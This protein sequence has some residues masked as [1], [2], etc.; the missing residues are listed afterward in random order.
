MPINFNNIT[1][2]A[3]P[4]LVGGT[5]PI[6]SSGALKLYK[7]R[8]PH[9]RVRRGSP[10]GPALLNWNLLREDLKEKYVAKYGDP[11]D[12]A[13]PRTFKDYIKVDYE[14]VEFFAQFILADGRNLPQEKQG[15][16]ATNAN[17]LNTLVKITNDR[18]ALRKALGGSTRTVW[19]DVAKTVE[20]LKTELGHTLP[21]NHIRLKQRVSQ[22]KA[23]G[24]IS[25]ISG[26]FL[27]N[28]AAKV[29]DPQQEATMRQLLRK[30]S[31]LDNEQIR[32]LYNIVAENLEW[33]QITA[34]TVANYRDKWELET[35][36]GRKG[37][38]SFDNAKA[39]LVKRKAPTYPLYYWTADG[40]D[41][42]LLY[43]K[44]ETDAKGYSKTTYHNRLTMVVI[45][46]PSAKYPIGYAIGTHETPQL[47]KEAL[48]NAVTHTKEIFG[49]YYKVLQLQTDNYGKKALT[50]IY[51]VISEKFT[52]ARVHN[53]KS[54]VVEPYFKRLNKK[55]CQL[56][57]N[58]SGFGVT[59]NP[60][61]QPNAEYLNKIRHSFPDE[62]GVRHQLTQIIEQERAIALDKYLA[63][64]A[65]MPAEDKKPIQMDEFIYLLG[66]T[67]GF[68]NRLSAPGLVVTIEGEKH[69]YD[70]FDPQFRKLASV[71]WTVR[72]NPEDK[73]QVVASSADGSHRFLL[74]EKYVQ[75]M[76]LRERTENDSKQLAQVA[77]F[78][79]TMKAEITEGM[80]DDYYAVEE[81]FA[82]NPRLNGTLAKLVL[83]DSNGQHK[84]NKSAAR[85]GA[86]RKVLEKQTIK[87]EAEK[88][89]TWADSQDE[90]LKQKVDVNKFLNT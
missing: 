11:T 2:I 81:L 5:S 76:A 52:P 42:E 8:A 64:F 28:N 87:I 56:L 80:A 48:R 78:N 59:S 25:L 83:T 85:L 40:W 45:L 89:K 75:P 15:E 57:P 21:K 66:E 55:Y 43:Q 49:D 12:V 50:P 73:T 37:A 44:T 7:H 65:E 82:N 22:Y 47:I 27:N 58:W 26:K 35:Y 20:K 68:T 84:D 88:E 46:D 24:Y 39:M 34:Q 69:E 30:H 16:Y 13:G 60:K 32:S 18:L 77:G 29:V 54:K 31:N 70:T 90:Y 4:E 86:A 62:F 51:D 3:E 36:S 1:C 17:V 53:A 72:F 23:N 6:I 33:E 71:D 61:M 41:A 10:A 67:T 79:K 9:V 19:P 14:A 63:S 38:T 74:S